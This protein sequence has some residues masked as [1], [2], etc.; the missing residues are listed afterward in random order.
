MSEQNT[1]ATNT[2]AEREAPVPVQ[3]RNERQTGTT[4]DDFSAV[5]GREAVW[6]FTPVSQITDL[7]D[8]DLDGGS[9]G[10]R[11]DASAQVEV[12]FAAVEAVS[13]G[14]AGLP[15]DRAAANAWQ[16]TDEVLTIHVTGEEQ[17]LTLT[18][19]SFGESPRALHT[20]LDV[21]PNS[22]ATVVLRDTG[23]ARISENLEIIMG[24]HARLTFVHVQQFAQGAHALASHFAKL[25]TGA[26]LKHC[27]VSLGASV[28]RINPSFHL[29]GEQSS[30]ESLGAYFAGH[31]Q[32]HEHQVFVNHDAASTRSRVN[33]KGALEGADARTVWIGDVLIRQSGVGTDSY[34]QNRNLILADGARAD[35]IP[36]LEIETGDIEGAGHASATGR[37]DAEQLFYLMSRGI[38]EDDARKL[39]VRGFLLEV[40]FQLAEGE[41]RAELQTLLEAKI[42]AA[43]EATR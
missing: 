37:F 42:D 40:I 35:S 27:V 2:R 29:A 8:G 7:L 14:T 21:A 36:N 22:S 26:E 18:R 31:G 17:T 32:H 33:Y 6:K 15:E 16:Q 11:V 30:V 19:D 9:Y 23:S 24:E 20:I 13:R 34:E 12:A 25:S 5:T 10:H 4:R 38:S 41:L 3:T 39:V 28:A 43:L 1:L